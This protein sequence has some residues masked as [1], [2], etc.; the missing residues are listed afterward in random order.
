VTS[1]AKQVTSILQEQGLHLDILLDI[2]FH[3]IYL[4][5]PEFIIWSF[6]FR[7]SL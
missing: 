6:Q 2:N 1:K 5:N 3:A 4:S 7:E